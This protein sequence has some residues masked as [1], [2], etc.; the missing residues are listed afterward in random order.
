MEW[1]CVEDFESMF[2]LFYDSGEYGAFAP[3]L[4]PFDTTFSI[5]QGKL[6][7]TNIVQYIVFQTDGGIVC[8]II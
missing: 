1:Y 2:A 7:H 3:P 8:A 6:F 5:Y 4:P